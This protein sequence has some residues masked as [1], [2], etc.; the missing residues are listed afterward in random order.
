MW[1][2][3][4]W[5]FPAIIATPIFAF[6]LAASGRIQNQTYRALINAGACS[7]CYTPVMI[8]EEH[9]GRILALASLVLFSDNGQA[10]AALCIFVC[11]I[12]SFLFFRRRASKS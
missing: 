4:G 5:L 2:L 6:I 9:G 8:S 11:F 12:V 3:W 7:F 10:L 1:G